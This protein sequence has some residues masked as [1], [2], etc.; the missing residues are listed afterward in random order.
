MMALRLR[1]IPRTLTTTPPSL[2][3]LS[4]SSS[5]PSDPSS[6]SISDYFSD[7]KSSLRHRSQS[8]PTPS[9]PPPSRAP[10]SASLAEIRKNLSQFR[11][12]NPTDSPTSSATPPPAQISFQELYKNRVSSGKAADIK[13]IRDSLKVIRTEQSEKRLASISKFGDIF[14]GSKESGG[15][16]RGGLPGLFDRERNRE[17]GD[18]KERRLRTEFVRSYSY[19]EMGQKLM[20]LRPEE[21]EEGGEFSVEELS[22]RLVKL[23]EME[24]NETRNRGPVNIDDIRESLVVLKDSDEEKLKKHN[25]HRLSMID[26]GKVPE[27]VSKPPKEGLVEKYFHPDNMSSAEKLKIQLA[28]VRDEFKMSESDCGS[29]RVQVAQL[30]TKIKHLSSV[31]HKKDKHSL[32]GLQAMVQRR[33]KLLKYLRRTD[34]DS[35]CLVLSKLGLRDTPDVKQE[36]KKHYKN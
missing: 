29:A 17:K 3:R 28:E 5:D 16:D 33:K 7:V 20:M 4:S 2:T 31:L 26:I 32:K 30:T 19:E 14:G 23:R 13:S 9:P 27:Y 34:W 18:E 21:E 35:Y 8:P 6:S 36:Y 11:L 10:N 25:T 1:P 24:K 22:E 15:G 12:R